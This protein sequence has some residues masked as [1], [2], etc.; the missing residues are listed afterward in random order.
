MVFAD[1]GGSGWVVLFREYPAYTFLTVVVAALVGLLIGA[2]IIRQVSA[3]FSQAANESDPPSSLILTLSF[4]TL[5]AVVGGLVT[6]S[7]SAWTLAATGLGALAASLTSYFQLSRERLIGSNERKAQAMGWERPVV[8]LDDT[9]EFD[10]VVADDEDED[11]DGEED[12]MIPAGSEFT[13]AD[14]D[15]DEAELYGVEDVPPPDIPDPE[16]NPPQTVDSAT[17]GGGTPHTEKPQ[18]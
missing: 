6:N 10:P 5:V 11:D 4:L 9:Q 18:V 7:E 17:L 3:Y 13:S 15:E 16:N 14:E 2:L 12:G 8:G 1:D